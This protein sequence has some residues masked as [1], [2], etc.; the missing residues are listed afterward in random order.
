MKD[1]QIKIFKNKISRPALRDVALQRLQVFAGR[2]RRGAGREPADETAQKGKVN[3]R[4][5]AELPGKMR[6]GSLKKNESNM[7]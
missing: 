5:E 3:H 7:A 6:I 1:E 2:S 4:K